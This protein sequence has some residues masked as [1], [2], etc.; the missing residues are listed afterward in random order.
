[1]DGFRSDGNGG[2]GNL[3]DGGVGNLGDGGVVVLAVLGAT[4]EGSTGR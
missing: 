3:G 4:H 2:V 1:M